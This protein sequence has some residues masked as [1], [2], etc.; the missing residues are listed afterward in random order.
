MKKK[1]LAVALLASCL[2][3]TACGETQKYELVPATEEMKALLNSDYTPSIEIDKSEFKVKAIADSSLDPGL[4]IELQKGQPGIKKSLYRTYLEGE[5]GEEKE[6]VKTLFSQILLKEGK[7]EVVHYGPREDDDVKDGETTELGSLSE[8]ITDP[9]KIIELLKDK[10]LV[11]DDA[12]MLPEDEAKELMEQKEKELEKDEKEEKEEP[13]APA[14]NQKP[15][16]TNPPA[17]NKPAQN[18]QPNP[19]PKPQKP[20]NTAPAQNNNNNNNNANQGNNN[21][22]NRPAN[23]QNTDKNNNNNQT[24][25]APKNNNN[26]ENS[27][28]QNQGAQLTDGELNQLIQNGNQNNEG[29][30]GNNGNPQP[31]NPSN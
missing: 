2:M 31:V 9:K 17:Q 26:Q 5:E 29:N 22:Q 8:E 7:S 13:K 12:K 1:Q 10:D 25:Q 20:A 30:A 21:N 23:N 27:G 18:P 15:A 24:P 4:V 3:L 6:E 14:Q 28:K 16:V 19:A 11:D